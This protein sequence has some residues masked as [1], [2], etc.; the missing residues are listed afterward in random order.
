[1]LICDAQKKQ[2]ICDAQ[3]KTDLYLNQ[4]PRKSHFPVNGQGKIYLFQNGE[5]RARLL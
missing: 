2:T 4:Q 1:M 3:K 5:M